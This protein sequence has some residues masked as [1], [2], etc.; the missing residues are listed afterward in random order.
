MKW[1]FYN[2]VFIMYNIFSMIYALTE[3]IYSIFVIGKTLFNRVYCYIWF[4]NVPIRKGGE[5]NRS[6]F[7]Q[8]NYL[9]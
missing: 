7:F 8:D 9:L 2:N 1:V 6:V 5:L 3:Q 4:E